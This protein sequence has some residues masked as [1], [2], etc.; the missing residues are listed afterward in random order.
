MVHYFPGEEIPQVT[1]TAS[2]G[3]D[4]PSD[5]P[6][7]DKTTALE[8]EFEKTT[9]SPSDQQEVTTVAEVEDKEESTEPPS[10]DIDEPSTAAPAIEAEVVTDSPAIGEE[11]DEPTAEGE[12][13]TDVPEIDEIKTEAP[14]IETD[15]TSDVSETGAPSATETS[16][17][18]EETLS[19]T[20]VSS[21]EDKEIEET[22]ETTVDGF[23]PLPVLELGDCLKDGKVYQ[24]GT[25]VVPGKC[26]EFCTCEDGAVNC[27]KQACPPP[28]P[29]FLRCDPVDLTDRCCPTY[30]CRKYN[31]LIIMF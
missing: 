8:T 3:T 17:I 29:A 19:E 10:V 18:S 2:D 20:T 30:D 26:E 23:T 1:F 15:I 14:S 16:V 7:I 12:V 4:T 5:E 25:S 22:T 11:T 6:A 13:V 31:F 21:Q 28:P 24:N 27:L 9:L